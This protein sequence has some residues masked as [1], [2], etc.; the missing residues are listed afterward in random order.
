MSTFLSFASRS[1]EVETYAPSSGA[2]AYGP[3]PGGLLTHFVRCGPT[4]NRTWAVGFGDRCTTI[5]RWT[6]SPNDSR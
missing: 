5:I 2:A 1:A 4:R 3:I 6:L